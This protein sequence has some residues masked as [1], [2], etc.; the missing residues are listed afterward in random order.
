MGNQSYFRYFVLKT[1]FQALYLETNLS[2]ANIRKKYLFYTSGCNFFFSNQSPRGTVKYVC[3]CLSLMFIKVN[4]FVRRNFLL[5]RQSYLAALV[6][7]QIG[8]F[9]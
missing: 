3:L 5:P 2:S 8:S 7:N 9:K 4:I 6:S 1:K